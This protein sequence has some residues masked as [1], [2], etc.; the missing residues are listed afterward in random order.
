MVAK[1]H[2]NRS[3][4]EEQ[5]SKIMK[6]KNDIYRRDRRGN[7]Y[8]SFWD[9]EIEAPNWQWLIVICSAAAIVIFVIK[10]TV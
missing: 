7:I 6:Y 4:R 1:S 10:A 3:D 2:R 5:M 9:S 8:Q